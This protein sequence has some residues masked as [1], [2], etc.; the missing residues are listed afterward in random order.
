M[1][2]ISLKQVP[3]SSVPTPAAN[4]VKIFSNISDD[5]NLYIKNS[6]GNIETLGGGTVAVTEVTY[7]ELYNLQTGSQL[8]AGTYYLI[9][10]FETV[11]RQ[12]DYYLDGSIK[13]ILS[14]KGRPTGWGYQP[15]LVMAISTT[16]L[17]IDAYQPN[18]VGGGYT[19]F[20][21]DKIKY[22]LLSNQTEFGDFTRGRILERI[23][24]YGNRTDYDHRTVKFKRYQDYE[25]TTS[26][27]GT[28]T[29]YDCT[30]GDVTGNSTVFTSDLSVGDIII[31]DSKA[32]LGYD[33]GLKVAVISS[34][35]SMTVEVDSAYV[36]G[37]PSSVSLS[38]STNITP[39]SYTFTF[40]SFDF[41]LASAT[42]DYNQYKEVYFGQ[43]DSGDFDEYY[44]FSTDSYDNRFSDYSYVYFDSH[45]NN[46]ILSNNVFLSSSSNNRFD[47][48]S[49]NN[50][51]NN[52][53]GN[54]SSSNFSRNIVSQFT[55]NLISSN[56]YNNI[57]GGVTNNVISANF[58][59]NKL[60]TSLFFRF[61]EIKCNVDNLT[62]SSH[63]Y[64]P[65]NCQIFKNS[66]A[67]IKLSYYDDN[68]VL[69]VVN[70]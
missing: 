67:V 60:D 35:T 16:A 44:T 33:I 47:G 19:G 63:V 29:D 6:L 31:L 48:Q 61:N 34:N 70:P 37:V 12:P 36:G 45:P 59:N 64:L 18:I 7:T 9:T 32:D 68:S 25:R 8:V 28:I 50:T 23:D 4:Y 21:K 51:F 53:N 11:Y 13:P 62:F 52:A 5:G 40:K 69:T 14:L 2:N 15:I 58:I 66:L 56:F 10:N 26:L 30:T 46:L 20:Y 27:T 3:S 41:W 1:S 55:N 49:Y 24:E 39:I 43:S 42:G 22:D 54:L 17:S 38:N 65:Y 57:M